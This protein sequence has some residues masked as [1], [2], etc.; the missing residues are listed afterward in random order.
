MESIRPQDI[1]R[2]M[3]IHDECN[4]SV[5]TALT[6]ACY[7]PI[8]DEHGYYY[9]KGISLTNWG[10]VIEFNPSYLPED[11]ELYLVSRPAPFALPPLPSREEI[12]S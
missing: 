11:G 4:E 2:G 7:M 1:A 8:T 10:S 12:K 6:D 9:V 5:F 3:I